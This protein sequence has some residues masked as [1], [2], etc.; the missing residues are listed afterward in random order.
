MLENR[1]AKEDNILKRDKRRI[2]EK[3][4]KKEKEKK[5]KKKIKAEKTTQER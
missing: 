2:L 4:E 1:N 5:D 3:K